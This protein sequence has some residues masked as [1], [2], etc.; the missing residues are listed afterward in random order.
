[1]SRNQKKKVMPWQ[2]RTRRWVWVLLLL[3]GLPLLSWLI[4]KSYAANQERAAA[5]RL[6]P[7][8]YTEDANALSALAQGAAPEDNA[9]PIYEEAHGKLQPLQPIDVFGVPFLG[10]KVNN[11]KE[12]PVFDAKALEKAKQILEENHEA[13][14]LA[15]EG[16]KRSFLLGQYDPQSPWNDH[17]ALGRA[18][19][20]F[21][22]IEMRAVIALQERD[23]EGLCRDLDWLLS[24]NL[25]LLATSSSYSWHAPLGPLSE[26]TVP[27]LEHVLATQFLSAAEWSPFQTRLDRVDPVPY[28]RNGLVVAVNNALNF[29]YLPPVIG[30]VWNVSGL[31]HLQKARGLDFATGIFAVKQNDLDQWW[32]RLSPHFAA[33]ERRDTSRMLDV[34]TYNLWSEQHWR[35]YGELQIAVL[36][37]GLSAVIAAERYRQEQGSLPDRLEMLVPGYLSS[38]PIDP[39]DGMPMR[40]VHDDKR[41]AVYSLGGDEKDTQGTLN[42]MGVLDFREGDW[43]VRVEYA[44][45]NAPAG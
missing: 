15:E 34:L 2:R 36:L 38:V 27:L 41:M 43:P 16:G 5:A 1:M 17:G 28:F 22:L 9:M 32:K 12:L 30:E 6:A 39:I 42:R 4:F 37:R 24:F 21:E 44:A 7:F 45:A 40:Y 18:Q 23:R 8:G 19:R 31:Y 20:M 26:H 11:L 33:Q 13:L 10:L 3:A 35:L 29:R 14:T 25:Q